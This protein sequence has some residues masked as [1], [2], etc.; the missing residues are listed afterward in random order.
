MEKSI[1]KSEKNKS[2]VYSSPE[3]EV[4]LISENDIVRVSD[5]GEDRDEWGDYFTVDN[6]GGLKV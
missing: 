2:N 5:Y 6:N 4:L 3:L 1:N